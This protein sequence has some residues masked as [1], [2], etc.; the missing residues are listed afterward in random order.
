ML[1][2]ALTYGFECVSSRVDEEDAAVDTRIRDEPVSHRCELF[3]EVRGMLVL[4]LPGRS[5]SAAIL[6]NDGSLI[7]PT[8]LT[9]GSQHPSLLIISPYPGVSMMFRRSR[10][11]FSTMT[12]RHSCLSVE[13]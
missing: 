9:I 4:D 3:A 2:T 13:S 11:P 8:Y 6:A 12:A 7:P 5:R 10:T 1:T